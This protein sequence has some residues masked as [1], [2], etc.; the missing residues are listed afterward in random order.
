MAEQKTEKLTTEE[1]EMTEQ[2]PDE[3]KAAEQEQKEQKSKEQ[4]SEMQQ[5]EAR[6]AAENGGENPGGDAAQEPS[7]AG[8]EKQRKMV[9]EV[10]IQYRELEGSLDQIEE[11]IYDQFRQK[12]QDI[13][14]IEKLQ[15][16]V[17]PQDF[18]AYY[19]VNDSIFGKVAIF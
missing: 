19:V 13:S 15:I 6:K 14:M 3:K 12:G 2:K 8:E 17:K 1:Q 5:T 9:K 4:K 7:A 18:T 11:R 10:V 16:Y